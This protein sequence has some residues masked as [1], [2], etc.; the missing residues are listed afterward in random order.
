MLEAGSLVRTG[1]P[2]TDD[3]VA[4]I[5]SVPLFAGFGDK[6]LRRVAVIAKEVEFPAGKEIAKQGESGVGFHSIWEGEAEVEVDG[7]VHATLGPGAS[8]GEMSLL[9]GGARSATVRAITPLKTVSMTSW[10]FNGL[11]EQHPELMKK[12]LIELCRRLR[13]VEHRSVEQRAAD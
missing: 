9:D 2:M 8:F 3:V 1:G 11:L 4:R 6:D 7:E 5:R 13:A 12:L 10:D